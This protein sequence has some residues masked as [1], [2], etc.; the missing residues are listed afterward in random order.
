METRQARY[1]RTAR[2]A[3]TLAQALSGFVPEERV[4]IIRSALALL[5]ADEGISLTTG[6]HDLYQEGRTPPKRKATRVRWVNGPRK[7][8]ATSGKGKSH[9]RCRSCQQKFYA[10]AR[11]KCCP[12]CGSGAV[13]KQQ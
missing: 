5:P 6:N 7:F 3:R 2:A 8:Y 4:R 1:F 13:E 11:I 10:H 12:R 9:L